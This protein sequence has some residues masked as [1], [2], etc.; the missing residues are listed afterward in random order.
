MYKLCVNEHSQ[1]SVSVRITAELHR[2]KFRKYSA[3][4]FPQ[5]SI[6]VENTGV[7][8]VKMRKR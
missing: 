7:E 1:R 2:T 5:L 8:N 3:Q 4:F 6:S